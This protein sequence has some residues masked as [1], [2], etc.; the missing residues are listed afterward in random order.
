MTSKFIKNISIVLLIAICAACLSACQPGT[1]ITYEE[2]LFEF[3]GELDDSINENT[4]R[5][6]ESTEFV[7]GLTIEYVSLNFERISLSE[8][9]KQSGRNVVKNLKNKAKY[10]LKLF[11]RFEGESEGKY[12]DFDFVELADE[13]AGQIVNVHFIDAGQDV[14]TFDYEM[15]IY[16]RDATMFN[17]KFETRERGK[18]VQI[19]WDMQEQSERYSN[20]IV[21]VKQR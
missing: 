2:G 4:G 1:V 9:N 10:M 14:L 19:L 5:P 11:I 21:L 7:N 13:G 3:T 6:F 8:Y 18:Y 15:W 12:Y 17:S 20:T 16:M